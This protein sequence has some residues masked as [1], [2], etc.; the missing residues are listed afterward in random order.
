MWLSRWLIFL[1]RCVEVLSG[2]EVEVLVSRVLLGV[3]Y[4][5]MVGRLWDVS[6]CCCCCCEVE[7]FGWYCVVMRVMVVMVV[8]RLSC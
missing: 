6:C 2:L 5:W 7:R 4:V 1:M 3:V 8:L